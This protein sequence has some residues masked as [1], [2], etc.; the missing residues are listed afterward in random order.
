[1]QNSLMSIEL[2]FEINIDTALLYIL[3]KRLINCFSGY[4]EHDEH[5]FV[6]AD[7]SVKLWAN[8]LNEVHCVIYLFNL[9][10]VEHKKNLWVFFFP[11]M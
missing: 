6:E 9:K 8:A 1:M 11:L 7:S 5:F 4:P 10:K 3:A 2:F